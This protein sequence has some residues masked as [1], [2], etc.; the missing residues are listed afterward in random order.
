[1]YF[2]EKRKAKIKNTKKVNGTF[3]I[4]IKK[5]GT[6][7]LLIENFNKMLKSPYYHVCTLLK[8]EKLR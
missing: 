8:K 6:R 2:A 5:K 1:M 4:L 7:L 3:F